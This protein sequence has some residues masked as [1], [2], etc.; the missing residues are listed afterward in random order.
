MDGPIQ[1]ES[2]EVDAP[3]EQ[4]ALE[5]ETGICINSRHSSI[6]LLAH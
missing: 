6:G 5:T 1:H 3:L 2:R 4:D